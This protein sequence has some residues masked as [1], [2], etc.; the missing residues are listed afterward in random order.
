M[1][2]GDDGV[3]RSLCPSVELVHEREHQPQA[4]VVG[5]GDL[6]EHV[7]RRHHVGLGAEVEVHP[8][9]HVLGGLPRQLELGEELG[10]GD[11]VMET[12]A[13]ERQAMVDLA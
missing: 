9:Q 11:V 8:R 7:Q 1:G 4:A 12:A 10:E 3:E 2:V 13:T 6:R 5:P